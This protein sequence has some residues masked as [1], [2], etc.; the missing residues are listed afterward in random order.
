MSADF[1]ELRVKMVDGQVRTTDVTSAPLLDAMLVVPREMFVGAAQRDLAYIDEDIRIAAG[2]DGSRYLME[3]SPLAKLIQLAEINP[4]DSVLDVGC[5]TGYA[6]AILSR[7]AGSVVALENDSA[8]AETARSTLSS[9]GCGNVTVVQ[10]A[11]P[12]GHAAKAPYDVIFIGGSVAEVPAPLLD[13][14]AEGGRLVAVEGQGNSGVARLFFKAGGVV[15]GRRAFNAAIKPLP[16]FERIR[17]FE[18]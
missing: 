2:A 5:G 16:G 13:Q 14:L 18:F 3:A 4:T 6:S 7:L 9:L 15:T 12:Q 10:G 1:S 8:L 11:L 17:A